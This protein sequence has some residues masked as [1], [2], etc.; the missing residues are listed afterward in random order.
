MPVLHY[1]KNIPE[2]SHYVP[3]LQ[4]LVDITHGV[5]LT[6]SLEDIT[7]DV[8]RNRRLDYTLTC[9]TLELA[10]YMEV[11]LQEGDLIIHGV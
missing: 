10:R 9:D 6:Y 11:R 1:I 2:D 8:A 3:W 5:E 7:C 4:N